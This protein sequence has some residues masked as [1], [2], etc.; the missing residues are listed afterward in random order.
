MRNLRALCTDDTQLHRR[1]RNALRALALRAD[2]TVQETHGSDD[3]VALTADRLS[4]THHAGHTSCPAHGA[5]GVLVLLACR[6]VGDRTIER[7]I[8]HPGRILLTTVGRGTPG[9]DEVFIVVHNYDV[10]TSAIAAIPRGIDDALLLGA[11]L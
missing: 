6:G 2:L 7:Q 4:S 5:G 10:P 8:I 3:D 11:F 1:K 9:R